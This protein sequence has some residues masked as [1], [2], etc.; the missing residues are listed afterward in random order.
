MI[1]EINTQYTKNDRD[2][3]QLTAYNNSIPHISGI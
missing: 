1:E 3:S 2:V